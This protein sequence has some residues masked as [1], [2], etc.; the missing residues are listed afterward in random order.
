[1]SKITDQLTMEIVSGVS[2]QLRALMS[3]APAIQAAESLEDAIRVQ[4][5]EASASAHLVDEGVTVVVFSL[6]HPDDVIA[7]LKRASVA[8]QVIDISE[9]SDEHTIA[10]ISCQHAGHPV[11]IYIT[12]RKEPE[13]PARAARPACSAQPF[14]LYAEPEAA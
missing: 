4:G 13:T 14:S 1:M 8:H 7:A 3:A 11:Q 6:A 5:I 12:H 2:H 9:Y 10:L